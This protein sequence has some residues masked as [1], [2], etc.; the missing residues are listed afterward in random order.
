[1]MPRKYQKRPEKNTC[2]KSHLSTKADSFNVT[3]AIEVMKTYRVKALNKDQAEYFAEQRAR[4]RCK[5][6]EFA[7]RGT[8]GDIYIVSTT[9]PDL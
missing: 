2:L 7:V 1:M 3:L 5:T 8:V 4:E 9:S 6:L